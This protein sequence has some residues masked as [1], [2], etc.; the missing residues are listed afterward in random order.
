MKQQY[1]S[2]L[3]KL[4]ATNVLIIIIINITAVGKYGMV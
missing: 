1:I 4:R 2:G 3:F